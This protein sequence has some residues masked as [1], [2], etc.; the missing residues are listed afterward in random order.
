ME[1]PVSHLLCFG[2]GYT[3]RT[4]ARRLAAEG[5]LI[6]G[7]S[8]NEAGA[9]NIAALGYRAYVFDG[10]APLPLQAFEGVT[11]VVVSVPPDAAGDPVLR[12][13]REIFERLAPHIHWLAYLSTT[14]VYGDHHGDWVTEATALTPNTE[15]GARR[16]AAELA[17]L[18]LHRT[19]GLPVHI[20]RLAGI[21]GPRRNALVQLQNGTAR[22]I[23]K[24][25]QVFSRIHVD[26]AATVL[27]ASIRR[28]NPGAAYNVCDD[29]PAPPQ[30][31]V[32][33]GAALLGVS[34]PP[35]VAFADAQLSEMA[36]SF[37][38]DSKRVSNLRIKA[39]LGVELRYPSYREGLAAELTSL[40]R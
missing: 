13:H 23:V 40:R 15:R 5:W 28:P 30:D 20:F 34:A 6:T 35:V 19:R 37:Y 16:L 3:G 14:G 29:D 38:A 36:R 17:W 33:H 12:Q 24:P 25:G 4:L 11:H 21:Y 10:S 31:V 8:R 1:R 32:T 2:L 39:E 27:A 22:R 18:D 7:T 26:D 9:E